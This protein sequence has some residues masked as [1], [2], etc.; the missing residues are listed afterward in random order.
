MATSD[1]VYEELSVEECL[2]LMGA[3]HF[4]RVGVVVDGEPVIFP[5]NYALDGDEVVFRAAPGSLLSGASLGRVSFEV[6]EVEE[7]GRTGW[8][9]VVQGFGNEVTSTIDERSEHIRA[10]R[11]EPWVPGEHDHW[12][13]IMPRSITGRRLRRTASS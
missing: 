3:H 2:E 12:I 9:V 10:L 1:G 11:L 6:D 4:G 7:S 8:S 5:V 13:G